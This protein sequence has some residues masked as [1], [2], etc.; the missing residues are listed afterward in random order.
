VDIKVDSSPHH[1]I[2]F[3]SQW[4][5]ALHLLNALPSAQLTPD[6]MT[7]N[8]AIG[9]CERAVRR[10]AEGRGLRR[11]YRAWAVAVQARAQ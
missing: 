7:F 10:C 1:P 2:A 4:Q 6:A 8:A 11:R 9:A 5:L 3:R